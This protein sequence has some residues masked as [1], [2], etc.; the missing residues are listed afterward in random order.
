MQPARC[1]CL[2]HDGLHPKVAISSGSIRSPRVPRPQR[3]SGPGARAPRKEYRGRVSPLGRELR[4]IVTV[5]TVTSG[6]M[7]EFRAEEERLLAQSKC[8]ER[9]RHCS[10]VCALLAAC[11]TCPVRCLLPAASL[12][13]HLIR[14]THALTSPLLP[15]S[16]HERLCFCSKC[17][18]PSLRDSRPEARCAVAGTCSF[19]TTCLVC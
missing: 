8:G 11:Y 17:Y 16:W 1:T 7:S 14:T 12:P 2:G 15:P 19:T 4:K 18:L 3:S 10:T 6:A 13:R 9:S 5:R